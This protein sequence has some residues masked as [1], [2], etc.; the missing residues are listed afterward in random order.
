M[1]YLIIQNNLDKQTLYKYKT[2]FP[3]SQSERSF[4]DDSYED[5][6]QPEKSGPKPV[7]HTKRRVRLHNQIKS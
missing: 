4:T 5:N 7:N 1:Y 6:I 2:P 3:V